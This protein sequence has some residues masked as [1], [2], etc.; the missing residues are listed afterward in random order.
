M[1]GI[2]FRLSASFVETDAQKKRQQ[3][4]RSISEKKNNYIRVV[5]HMKVIGYSSN[6]RLREI[7]VLNMTRIA[8]GR[9]QE[10]FLTQIVFSVDCEVDDFY[11]VEDGMQSGTG[12]GVI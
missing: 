9:I 1:K 7:E 6:V 2:I 10:S 3:S 12:V 8:I 4:Y 5:T 11:E